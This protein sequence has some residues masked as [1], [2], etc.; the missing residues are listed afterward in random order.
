MKTTVRIVAYLD[1][2]TVGC[3]YKYIVTKDH[4]SWR[5]YRTAHGFKRF[6]D[7][8]GLKINPTATELRDY[9]SIGHGRCIYMECYPKE[10]IDH[11]GFGFWDSSAVPMEAKHYIDVVNGSYVDCYI[12]DTGDRVETF[13]PN[14]NAKNVYRPYDYWECARLYS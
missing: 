12:L 14:P 1:G 7:L 2:Q 6:L 13:K 3:G 8:F 4:G 5:A 9:R 11:C 10:V